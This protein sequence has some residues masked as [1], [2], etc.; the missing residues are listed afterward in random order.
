MAVIE[1]ETLEPEIDGSQRFLWTKEQYRNLS[2]L[3]LLE[4]V[5]VELIEGE[6]IQMGSV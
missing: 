2:E 6:I 5:R 4:E 3:G 1:R